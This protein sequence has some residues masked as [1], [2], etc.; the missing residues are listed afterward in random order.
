MFADILEL[1]K[2]SMP[3]TP[4]HLFNTTPE[5]F[6]NQSPMLNRVSPN[7]PDMTDLA[8]IEGEFLRSAPPV[9]PSNKTEPTNF[10]VNNLFNAYHQ[11]VR[12]CDIYYN[13]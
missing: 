11:E 1:E 10:S 3:P 9:N 7:Q 13:M 2:T 6:Y 5:M 4:T 8:S 12:Y